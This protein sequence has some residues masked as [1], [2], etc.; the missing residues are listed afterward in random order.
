MSEKK[1]PKYLQPKEKKRPSQIENPEDK[2]KL[3]ISW[4]FNRMVFDQNR[5]WNWCIP[6]KDNIIFALKKLSDIESNTFFELIQSPKHHSYQISDLP[7]K[8]RNEFDKLRIYGHENI[9]SLRINGEPRVYCLY[10][11]NEF[12]L[13]WLDLKHEV[14]PSHK[15]HT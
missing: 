11:K 8:S 15:K 14:Y 3:P 13:L 2:I 9:F 1:V 5:K 4:K 6:S 7:E 12:S 10:N